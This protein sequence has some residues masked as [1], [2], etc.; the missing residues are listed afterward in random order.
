MERFIKS[1]K[2]LRCRK[3]NSGILVNGKTGLCWLCKVREER[4]FEV[5]YIRIEREAI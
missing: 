1:Q 4:I 5:G 3:C 2:K